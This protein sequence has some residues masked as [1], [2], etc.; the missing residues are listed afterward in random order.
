M[1]SPSQPEWQP[2]TRRRVTRDEVQ[3]FFD[4]YT[5]L[6]NQRGV[7]VPA[8]LAAKVEVAKSKK[9]DDC[10]F[11]RLSLKKADITDDQVKILA[12]TLWQFPIVGQLDLRVNAISHH[13]ALALVELMRYQVSKENDQNVRHR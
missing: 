2:L 6:A 12:F 5:S 9:S 1:F 8:K 7:D 11:S 3:Y 13:G 10:R 4:L